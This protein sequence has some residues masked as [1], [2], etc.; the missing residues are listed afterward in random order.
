M[1]TPKSAK[2]IILVTRL[3]MY[4]GTK[5]GS[6]RSRIRM[7]IAGS[8]ALSSAAAPRF[9]ARAAGSSDGLAHEATH[10]EVAR[11]HLRRHQKTFLP[12]RPLGRTSRTTM[13][14]T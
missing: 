9:S 11:P 6:T 5:F 13:K 3:W 1:L 10:E 14:M 2:I 4:D 12:M 7:T 8:H